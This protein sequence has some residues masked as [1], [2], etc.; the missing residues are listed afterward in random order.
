[1]KLLACEKSTCMLWGPSTGQDQSKASLKA[2]TLSRKLDLLHSAGESS[3]EASKVI[4]S[5]RGSS[6][7]KINS[8]SKN[9]IG[10]NDS[11]WISSEGHKKVNPTPGSGKSCSRRLLKF[12]NSPRSFGAPNPSSRIETEILPLVNPELWN[13]YKEVKHKLQRKEKLTDLNFKHRTTKVN[14]S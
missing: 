2:C 13:H 12:W 9:Y 8:S 11:N 5:S 10:P 6:T 14:L 7:L 1:M 4:G 3:K